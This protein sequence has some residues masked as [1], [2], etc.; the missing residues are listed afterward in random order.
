MRDDS[1]FTRSIAIPVL[2]CCVGESSRV[3]LALGV[4]HGHRFK[5][6]T[7]TSGEPGLRYHD[8]THARA[9][10]RCTACRQWRTRCGVLRIVRA[11]ANPIDHSL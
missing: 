1:S 8:T 7:A 6:K 2:V 11:Y 5:T 4:T 9:A 3:P 10:H